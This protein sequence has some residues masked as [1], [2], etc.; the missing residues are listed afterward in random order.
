MPGSFIGDWGQD[1]LSTGLKLVKEKTAKK[2][3]LDLSG[4]CRKLPAYFTPFNSP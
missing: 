1:G 2:A 3:L 4:I